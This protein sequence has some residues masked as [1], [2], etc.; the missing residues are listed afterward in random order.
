M[1][2]FYQKFEWPMQNAFFWCIT[3]GPKLEKN[4]Q[5]V[6]FR[7]FLGGMD[8]LEGTFIVFAKFSRGHVYSRGHAYSVL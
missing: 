5:K 3:H 7:N 6:D 1:S 8:I 2:L 4:T